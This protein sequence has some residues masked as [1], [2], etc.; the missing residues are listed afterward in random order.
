MDSTLSFHMG[1]SFN[2]EHN[3]RTIPVPHADKEYEREHNWYSPN[4]M[5]LEDAYELLFGEEFQRYN[6]SVRADRRYNSYLE[7]LQIACQK[8]KEKIAQLRHSGAPSSQIR[9]N[10]NAVK[11]AYEII[12]GLGNARDNPEF[13]KNGRLQNTA[14]EILVEFIENFQKENPN[15]FL[16][17]ASLHT[18]ESGSI[19]I[20]ADV[21]FFCDN[22]SRGMR[23]QTS[24]TKALNAMGYVSDETQN[25]EGVRLNAITKWENKQREI[26]RSLCAKR[27]ITIIDGEHSRQHLTTEEFQIKRDKDFVDEQARELMNQIDDF[28]QV[29]STSNSTKAYVE[30]Q[31]NKNLREKVTAYEE[32][33]ARRRQIVSDAWKEFN[34]CTSEYFEV[35]RR[36]K[37]ELFAELQRARKGTEENRKKLKT[38][39]DDIA[40]GND[41]FLIKL[42]KLVV[43]LFVA[44]ETRAL[45]D[46]VKFLQQKN[47]ELKSLAKNVISESQTV[48]ATLRSKDID[49]I[50]S[51][52][53]GY[54]QK[55]SILLRS[56]EHSRENIYTKAQHYHSR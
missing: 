5:S 8:E 21:I 52:M 18:G 20:H 16:Y 51:T 9:R 4:N 2:E 17:N 41:F 44:M 50:A 10:K 56:I 43:A 35:Y 33:E 54:E 1:T 6:A 34:S 27:G 55:L 49:R 38:L 46:D 3:N 13:C 32:M 48:S 29:V 15:V 23:R 47:E 36:H 26:L 28:V 53:S 22:C 31:E 37:K 30:H 42:F 7:K 39:L 11:P 14:K 25:S 40:Y 24:L 45:D 12:I 19:H